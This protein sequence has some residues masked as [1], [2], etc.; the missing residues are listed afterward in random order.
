VISLHDADHSNV[1]TT[2]TVVEV[3]AGASIRLGPGDWYDAPHTA[4]SDMEG[5]VVEHEAN[6]LRT[7]GI[8]WWLVDVAGSPG[9]IDEGHLTYVSGPVGD[10]DDDVGDD[11]TG[12]MDDDDDLTGDDDATPSDDDSSGG[13][14]TDDCSCSDGGAATGPT[15]LVALLAL[16]W[17]RRQG[18]PCAW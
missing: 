3:A 12:P 10:D 8:D 2:G 5:E 11:D 4:T 1:F 7:R 13:D 18:H 16:G 14:S 17:A 6:G 15:W 9:W